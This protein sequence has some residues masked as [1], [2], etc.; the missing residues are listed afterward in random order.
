[1][2]VEIGVY[3]RMDTKLK[4]AVYLVGLKSPLVAVEVQDPM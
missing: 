3:P 4:P 2:L 1:M